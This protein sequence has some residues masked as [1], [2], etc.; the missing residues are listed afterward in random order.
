MKSHGP[1]QATCWWGEFV[2]PTQH[3]IL[4]RGSHSLI[5][6]TFWLCV[7]LEKWLTCLRRCWQRCAMVISLVTITSVWDNA[8]WEAVCKGLCLMCC[9]LYIQL[10]QTLGANLW[11]QFTQLA[12]ELKLGWEQCSLKG[13]VQKS[14]RGDC[15][16]EKEWKKEVPKILS[17][18]NIQDKSTTQE[19]FMFYLSYVCHKK[20]CRLKA[21]NNVLIFLLITNSVI[22]LRF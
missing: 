22:N 2:L 14:A 13:S 15:A 20:A 19:S 5:C 9:L 7:L 16:R 4:G 3:S 21:L 12:S 18:E 17:R 11:G 6:C 8:W 1:F 10:G